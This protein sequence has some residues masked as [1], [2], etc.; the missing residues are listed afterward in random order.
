VA[1]RHESESHRIAFDRVIFVVTRRSR[2]RRH[3]DCNES[4][5]HPEENPMRIAIAMRKLEDEA[6]EQAG[7]PA[8]CF[9]EFEV[10]AGALQADDENVQ[11]MVVLRGKRGELE[12]PTRGMA[13]LVLRALEAQRHARRSD[14]IDVA[15][16]AVEA[17]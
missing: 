9:A 7:E 4:E 1:K 17:R 2:A 10:D 12:N 11:V 15:G 5:R 13:E 8:E 3:G 6:P 16:V 14:V